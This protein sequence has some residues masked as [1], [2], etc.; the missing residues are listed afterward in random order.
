M[1]EDE[2]GSYLDKHLGSRS[3]FRLLGWNTI[4]THRLAVAR[5]LQRKLLAPHRLQLLV[6]SRAQL[7]LFHASLVDI[8]AVGL[9]NK[10]RESGLRRLAHFLVHIL[11]LQ[12]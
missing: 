3:E 4:R 11:G 8:Q 6:D 10:Y 9:L 2:S 12:M 1:D 5:E 7:L